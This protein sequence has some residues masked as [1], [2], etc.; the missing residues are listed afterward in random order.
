MKPRHFWLLYKQELEDQQANKPQP[1]KL[2]KPEVRRLKR[3]IEED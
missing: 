2:T 1:G 3:L